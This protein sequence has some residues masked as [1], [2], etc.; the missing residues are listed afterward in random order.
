MLSQKQ[1]T[2]EGKRDKAK[3]IL[4]LEYSVGK[5]Q[6]IGHVSLLVNSIFG[7]D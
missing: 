5:E 1:T 3:S 6:I 2:A 4:C 7:L